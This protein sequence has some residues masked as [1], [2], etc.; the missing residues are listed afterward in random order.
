MLDIK[1]CKTTLISHEKLQN[2]DKHELRATESVHHEN[3]SFHRNLLSVDTWN[4]EKQFSKTTNE[5]HFFHQ[6]FN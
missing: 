4:G 6:K 1:I 2:C 3:S 5:A